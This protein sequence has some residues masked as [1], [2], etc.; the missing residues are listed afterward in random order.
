MDSN[1]NGA[2]LSGRR[3]LGLKVENPRGESL[4]RIEDIMVGE[5]REVAYAVV[6]FGG[7]LSL[8]KKLFAIPWSA[9]R[10][11]GPK[12]KVILNLDR[13]LL[14]AARGFEKGHGPDSR[15]WNTAAY[16]PAARVEPPGPRAE[17][18]ALESASAA[19]N[20]MEHWGKSWNSHGLDRS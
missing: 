11:D 12:S 17:A 14:A 6:S 20:R 16:G 10:V 13:D 18:V 1:D 15:D 2:F 19:Q 8:G 7:A 3:L 9:L 4:G 5:G